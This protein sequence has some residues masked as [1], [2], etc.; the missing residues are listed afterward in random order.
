MKI[1]LWAVGVRKRGTKLC[2][3]QMSPREKPTKHEGMNIVSHQEFCAGLR[4]K[5][6]LHNSFQDGIGSINYPIFTWLISP[7]RDLNIPLIPRSWRPPNQGKWALVQL[8][9]CVAYCA[10][11]LYS[12]FLLIININYKE[13]KGSYAYSKVH[14]SSAKFKIQDG[15]GI[16]KNERVMNTRN[17]GNCPFSLFK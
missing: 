10:T 16:A 6:P 2:P 15:W 12:V 13:A 3:S 14:Q 4:R 7:L 17:K 8:C 5:K 1:H 11:N 9:P